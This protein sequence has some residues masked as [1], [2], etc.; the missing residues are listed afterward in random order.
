ML[1]N[2]LSGR[3]LTT[4]RADFALKT[5]SSFVNGLMPLRAFVKLEETQVEVI[6][7]VRERIKNKVALI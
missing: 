2:A 4:F 7:E 6:H 5:V 3:I 1:F